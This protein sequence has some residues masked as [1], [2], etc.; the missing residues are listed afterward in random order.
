M[1]RRASARQQHGI[2]RF[3]FERFGEQARGPV[4]ITIAECLPARI[5]QL[6][7]PRLTL[8]RH[9]AQR[10]QAENRRRSKWKHDGGAGKRRAC[11]DVD[12]TVSGDSSPFSRLT[13]WELRLHVRRCRMSLPFRVTA[14]RSTMRRPS[15]GYVVAV[16]AAV[17]LM[18]AVAFK[19]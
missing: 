9:H 19:A 12:L 17:G 7:D 5:V 14:R 2:V 4:L 15:L 11:R 3:Q 10:R 6:V 16:V 8:N 18:N 1:S 13:S